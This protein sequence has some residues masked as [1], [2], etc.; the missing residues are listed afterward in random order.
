MVHVDL[1]LWVVVPPH[2]FAI[3]V[4]RRAVVAK[5]FRKESDEPITQDPTFIHELSRASLATSQPNNNQT[6]FRASSSIGGQNLYNNKKAPPNNRWYQ[7]PFH[8]L[9]H[10]GLERTCTKKEFHTA[11]T[12]GSTVILCFRQRYL[13]PQH[14]ASHLEQHT[15]QQTALGLARDCTIT[16]TITSNALV[17]IIVITVY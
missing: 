14:V 15:A 8:L 6:F 17:R 3:T 13:L 4:N 5:L 16:T 2:I 11:L 9:P 10:I 12:A 7:Y 1:L